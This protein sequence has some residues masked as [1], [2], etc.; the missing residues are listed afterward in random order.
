MSDSLQQGG[1]VSIL[2][3]PALW[4]F[5]V[6]LGVLSC[7]V[8]GLFRALLGGLV[9]RVL[10]LCCQQRLQMAL[11]VGLKALP[12]VAT[13]QVDSKHGDAKNWALNLHLVGGNG[14]K[15]CG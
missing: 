15:A 2:S 9:G 8:I 12:V 7:S 3:R 13:G 1:V 10:Q 4:C 14:A 11:A 5:W 6:W